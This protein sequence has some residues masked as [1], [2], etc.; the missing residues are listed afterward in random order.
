PWIRMILSSSATRCSAGMASGSTYAMRAI[1][2]ASG[3]LG[4]GGRLRAYRRHDVCVRRAGPHD[5]GSAAS[6][7]RQALERIRTG[8]H[9]HDV[10]RIVTPVI[11][12]SLLHAIGIGVAAPSA[13]GCDHVAHARMG[14]LRRL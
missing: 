10:R 11:V 14:D 3:L 4:W 8:L 12:R 9:Y 6:A 13:A 5:P 1:R 2:A 7:G